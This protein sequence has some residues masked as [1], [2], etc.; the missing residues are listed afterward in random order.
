VVEYRLF[1]ALGEVCGVLVTDRASGESAFR[2]RRDWPDFAGPEA[3]VL[4]AIAEDLP[5]K[6]DEMGLDGFLSWVDDTLSLTFRSLDARQTLAGSLPRTAQALFHQ[7]VKTTVKPFVTHL[8]LYPIRAAAGGFGRDRASTEPEEWIDVPEGGRRRLHEDEMLVRVEGTSME[9]DI[10]DGAI[11]RFRRYA[12]GSRRGGIWL[13]MRV[14]GGEVSGEVTLKRYDR[15]DDRPE[16]RRGQRL[17]ADEFNNETLERTAP[18]TMHPLN[19]RDHRDWQLDAE[20]G[21]QFLTIAQFL[22][23]IE[24]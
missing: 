19:Q 3:G 22:D 2:F 7:K 17:E 5:G 11:C 24:D 21:D 15:G 20:S 12:G 6:L 23:V 16:A 18:A 1:E 8:P 9:P 13:V 10:P 4:E 14:T